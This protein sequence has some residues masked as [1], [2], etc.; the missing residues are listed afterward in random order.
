MTQAPINLFSHYIS[1]NPIIIIIN[2]GDT[3]EGVV[4]RKM[5]TPA[6]TAPQNPYPHWHKI[7]ETLP[8]L[9]QN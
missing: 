2:A 5:Y 8:L 6:R 1:R 3:P 4:T 7:C 9:A